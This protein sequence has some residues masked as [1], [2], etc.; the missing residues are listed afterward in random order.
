MALTINVTDVT[1]NVSGNI[2]VD[3]ACEILADSTEAIYNPEQRYFFKFT[4]TAKDQDSLSYTPRIVKD[5]GE[6]ALNKNVRSAS[7]STT[8]YATVKE[9]IDDYIYDYINGHDLDQFSSG[10]LYRAPMKI[11]N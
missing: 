3:F 11:K 4:T 6:L 9:L 8:D 1:N 2:A 7:N 10:V 5:F